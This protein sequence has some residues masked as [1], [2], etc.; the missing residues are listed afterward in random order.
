M[1][2]HEEKKIEEKLKSIEQ[3]YGASEKKI[4]DQII[5]QGFTSIM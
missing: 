2:R 1:R 4:R 3:S 5:T